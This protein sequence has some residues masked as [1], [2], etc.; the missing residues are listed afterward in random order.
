VH[1]YKTH[2]V[3]LSQPPRRLRKT[4]YRIIAQIRAIRQTQ[5]PQIPE[6]RV[7]PI[8]KPRIR[9]CR[10]SRQIHTLDPT[11]RMRRNMMHASIRDMLTVA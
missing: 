2:Q 5:F 6:L 3:Q 7:P 1:E 8:L 10:A 4:Y 11:R 9:N